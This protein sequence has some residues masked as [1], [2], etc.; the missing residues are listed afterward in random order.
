ME[1]TKNNDGWLVFWVF[2]GAFA[3]MLGGLWIG[4]IYH[5][6]VYSR[7]I[8][9]HI[10]F[11]CFPEYEREQWDGRDARREFDK[12]VD[13]MNNGEATEQDRESAFNYHTENM[14]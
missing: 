14:S 8:V 7:I 10:D 3:L 2:T 9:T 1:N 4:K 13:R 12:A 6:P 5:K 11:E